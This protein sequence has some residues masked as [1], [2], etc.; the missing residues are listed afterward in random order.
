MD[1][2]TEFSELDHRNPLPLIGSDC[3]RSIA[4]PGSG[5]APPEPVPMN[6]SPREFYF[7]TFR[8]NYSGNDSPIGR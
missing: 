7:G 6:P 8:E 2:A 4:R 5:G 3:R 1:E